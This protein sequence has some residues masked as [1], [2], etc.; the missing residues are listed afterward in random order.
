[1]LLLLQPPKADTIWP[2]H[3]CR[4]EGSVIERRACCLRYFLVGV[5]TI[6]A[7]FDI[8]K[9][10][11]P[12]WLTGLGLVLGIV[13]NVWSTGLVGLRESL[14]GLAVG[15]GVMLPGYLIGGLGGGDVKLM[16]AIGSMVGPD[17][18]VN[19]WIGSV[20]VGGVVSLGLMVYHRR[21]G[22]ALRIAWHNL[23]IFYMK[24]FYRLDMPFV[25]LGRRF[26]MPYAIA[27]VGG[28]CLVAFGGVR[29]L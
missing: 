8:R 29:F 12:N 4:G 16:A 18:L 17:A 9:R 19:S 14:L 6:A 20:L 25:G 11:I 21:L 2:L 15:F 3:P 7:V 10:I 23:R 22:N 27:I 5:L 13:A 28:T 24:A 1:M 26:T